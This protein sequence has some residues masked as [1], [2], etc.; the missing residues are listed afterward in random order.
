MWLSTNDT[1][2]RTPLSGSK[3][4]LA[5]PTVHGGAAL[6]CPL[7]ITSIPSSSTSDGLS[8]CR[9]PPN[10]WGKVALS[11][12]LSCVTPQR[13]DMEVSLIFPHQQPSPAINDRGL[14][15][16]SSIVIIIQAFIPPWNLRCPHHS[17][18][19]IPVRAPDT[20]YRRLLRMI[21]ASGLKHCR[22]RSAMSARGIALLM[23][24][25]RCP[26]SASLGSFMAPWMP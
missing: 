8:I 7:P 18:A 20:P 4:G 16:T 5:L 14:L 17:S 19:S 11:R 25:R 10:A 2:V 24:S 13:P 6:D 9:T 12:W 26:V 15:D 22:P 1:P 23:A 3:L 21:H